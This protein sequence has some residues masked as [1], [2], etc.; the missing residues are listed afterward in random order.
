MEFNVGKCKVIHLGRGNEKYE[1]TMRG[2]KLQEVS[3]EKDLGVWIESSLKSH[4]QA[5]EAAKKGYQML[6]FINRNFA[7]R[8]K[9]CIIKLYKHYVRPH[10]EYA[11]Q[12]WNPHHEMDIEALERV[13]SR[14]TRMI[15]GFRDLSYED[16]LRRCG[17]TTLK[18]RRDRGILRLS[19]THFILC[20]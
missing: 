3:E 4:K 6:G 2:E 16:R 14:A 5:S 15:K 1:Y 11:V 18:T 13:Q 10:L 20:V 9:N 17:L 7:S 19:Y 8:N 12:A